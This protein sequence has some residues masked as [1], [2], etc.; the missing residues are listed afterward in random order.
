[1]NKNNWNKLDK[2]L[3]DTLNNLSDIDLLEWKEKRL[4][5]KK[6]RQLNLKSDFKK[7]L[8]SINSK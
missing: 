4:L 5:N 7:K 2:E 8:N 6:K 1:M 3:K